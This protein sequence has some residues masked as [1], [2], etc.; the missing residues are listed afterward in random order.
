MPAPTTPA[1]E[2]GQVLPDRPLPGDALEAVLK[3][4]RLSDPLLEFDGGR[5]FAFVPKGFELKDISDPHRLPPSIH[6]RVTVDDAQSLIDYANR[7][8]DS[9]SVII[10]DLDGLVIG[11]A[12]DWHS[13]NCAGRG[14]E[15]YVALAPQPAKHLAALKLRNSEEFARWAGMENKLHDQMTFAEFLDENSSDIVDP[16]PAVMIEIA[17]DL[18]ATQG[19]KFKAGTRLQTGER[20]FS[21]E[22]ETHVKGDLKV[23]QR[24]RLAI[25]LFHGEEPTEI[26]AS[27]RFRPN[28]DGLKLGFVWRR[29]EFVRQAKFREIAHRVAEMTGLPVFH[30]RAS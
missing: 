6:Q 30:G 27:F 7:F 25:P 17:R 19:V 12:L 28:P 24:F 3:G 16:D 1:P 4:V 8:S 14:L 10:A 13:S 18:E 29:V 11:V 15:G 2:P 5:A 26:E 20:S 22:T 23:P 9:R 21:Y